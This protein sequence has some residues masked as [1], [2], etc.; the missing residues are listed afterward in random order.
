MYNMA[1]TLMVHAV[2]Q[3]WFS[4]FARIGEK[5]EMVTSQEIRE[6]SWGSLFRISAILLTKLFLSSLLQATG[7]A[8]ISCIHAAHTKYE[9]NPLD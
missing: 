9:S 1:D 8:V 2:D 5:K 4:A 3:K 6:V 7:N